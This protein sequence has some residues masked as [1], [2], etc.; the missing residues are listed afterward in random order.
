[1]ELPQTTQVRPNEDKYLAQW[2][3]HELGD[4]RIQG[5]P[6]FN[7]PTLPDTIPTGNRSVLEEGAWQIATE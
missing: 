3:W 2:Y 6:Q 4:T 7:R 1:M 5:Y